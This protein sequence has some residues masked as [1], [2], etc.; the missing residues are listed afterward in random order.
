MFG[1]FKEG[2][3]G[4]IQRTYELAAPRSSPHGRPDPGP[5][6]PGPGLRRSGALL[7]L[8]VAP[9]VQLA[10]P[11]VAGGGER[12]L[13][14]GTLQTLLVP[15]GTVD[16]HQEA[17]RDDA[18]AGLTEGPRRGVPP[19]ETGGRRRYQHPVQ[20]AQRRGGRL[21]APGRDHRP[22][23]LSCRSS[24]RTGTLQSAWTDTQL[25]VLRDVS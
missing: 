8:V 10:V 3:V 25:Q 23:G 20:R 13:A 22:A 6:T 1:S 12:L 19:W 24:G 11:E 2:Y 7:P 17:V 18:G 21:L 4:R 14:R 15:R 5:W 9:A 16:P